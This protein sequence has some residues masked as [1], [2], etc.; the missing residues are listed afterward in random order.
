MS[1]A[2]TFKLDR[3]SDPWLDEQRDLLQ[4]G[5]LALDLGSGSG[6]DSADLLR[7]GLDVV[8]FDQSYYRLRRVR[9]RAPE[10]RLVR[11]DMRAGLPFPD[12]YFDLVVASL[13]IHYFD[14]QTSLAI[15]A[16]IGRVL[17]PRHWFICRVNRVGDI[18]FEY[19]KGREIEPEYFEV[20]PGHC[21]RFFTEAMLR[22]LL[23][24]TFDVDSIVPRVS[25]R[26]M[27]EKQTLVARARNRP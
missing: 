17:K 8:A 7:F 10:A 13:S 20:R 3:P 4:P 18:Q 27:K 9:R 14:W 21:K 25:K 16:E 6:E 12:A 19:G 26:W 23:E 2:D 15:A 24:T 22:Q 5:E 1:Q 11:G